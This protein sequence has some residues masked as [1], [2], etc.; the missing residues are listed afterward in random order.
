MF[1]DQQLRINHTNLITLSWRVIIGSVRA[2]LFKFQ[3]E[4]VLN[5]DVLVHQMQIA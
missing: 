4:K 3:L 5:Q 2:Q 1:N